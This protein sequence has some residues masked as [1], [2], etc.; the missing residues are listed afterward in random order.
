MSRRD[1]LPLAVIAV[2]GGML[3]PLAMLTGL[4][5][6]SGVSGSLLLNLE[7]PF[8][9]LIAGLLFPRAPRPP[10]GAARRR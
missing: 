4:Q 3:S 2:V 6:V 5:R 8:T 9:M 1:L 10:A 7:A